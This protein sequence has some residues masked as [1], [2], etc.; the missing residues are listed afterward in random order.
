MGGAR[1]AY[2]LVELGVRHAALLGPIERDLG[3]LSLRGRQLALEAAA[4]ELRLG[5]FL[6]QRRVERD[7]VDRVTCRVLACHAGLP[8]VGLP[9]TVTERHR[10]T[11]S[12]GVT[13]R[14]VRRELATARRDVVAAPRSA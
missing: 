7:R 14:L 9:W 2:R 1:P 4:L 13:R 8:A 12:T 11:V 6:G 5:D 3:E 10:T